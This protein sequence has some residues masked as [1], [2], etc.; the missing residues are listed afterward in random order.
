MAAPN[1]WRSIQ[2][3]VAHAKMMQHFGRTPGCLTR[4]LQ[5][6]TLA[7]YFRTPARHR[8][9]TRRLMPTQPRQTRPA[10]A[11]HRTI[12]MLIH[13]N[14]VPFPLAAATVWLTTPVHVGNDQP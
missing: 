11:T 14:P 13:A 10:Y 9:K 12:L 6:L 5:K 4:P 8:A 2:R 1:I 7:R 3:R